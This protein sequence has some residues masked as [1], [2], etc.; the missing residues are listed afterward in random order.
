MVVMEVFEWPTGHAK[1]RTFTVSTRQLSSCMCC[2]C[3]GWLD[4]REIDNRVYVSVCVRR[5]R[6][7]CFLPI[8]KR[9]WEDGA[10]IY[11]VGADSLLSTGSDRTQREV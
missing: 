7:F 3:G 9:R 11:G 2:Q 4:L 5:V 8:T 10:L 1:L 6:C